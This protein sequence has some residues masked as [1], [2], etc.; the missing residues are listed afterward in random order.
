[1]IA[2]LKTLWP[3]YPHPALHLAVVF[4]GLGDKE[5]VMYWLKQ[6]E[7]A[8]VSDLIG[9]GASTLWCSGWARYNGNSDLLHN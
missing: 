1:M 4:S 3:G 8:H 2:E 6:A 5:N 7:Q 9:I